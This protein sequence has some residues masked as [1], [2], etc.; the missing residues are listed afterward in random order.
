M[1]KRIFRALV[2]AVMAV[3]SIAVI[4]VSPL[5]VNAVAVVGI[6]DPVFEARLIELGYDDA[7][8]GVVELNKI[9]RV[10]SLDLSGLAIDDLDGI[11]FF[12]GLEELNLSGLTGTLNVIGFDDYGYRLPS[13]L[14]TLNVS[15][16]PTVLEINVPAG[17][18]QTNL[19]SI[20]LTGNTGLGA[21]YVQG[22][23]LTSLDITGLTSLHTLFV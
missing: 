8:D 4:A 19:E 6:S 11:E 22:A 23:R 13:T 5:P 1:S 3:A 17:R 2:T 20:N 14:R 15:N 21:L 12:S 9:N 7:V 10:K 18:N 16:N